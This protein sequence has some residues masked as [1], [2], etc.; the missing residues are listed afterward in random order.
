[1]CIRDRFAAQPECTDSAPDDPCVGE[2]HHKSGQRVRVLVV[3]VPDKSKLVDLAARIQR[4]VEPEGGKAI[5]IEQAG[6]RL[7]RVVRPVKADDG[8]DLVVIEYI[9][10]SPDDNLLHMVTSSAPWEQQAVADGRVRDLL[11]FAAW[12]QGS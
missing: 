1:M 11:A 2:W 4:Q 8:Q 3:P 5:A 6:Q 12:V 10:I 7:V 9:L